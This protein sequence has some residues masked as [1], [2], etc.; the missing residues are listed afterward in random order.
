MDSEFNSRA[1]EHLFQSLPDLGQEAPPLGPQPLSWEHDTATSICLVA[2]L[3]LTAAANLIFF[4]PRAVSAREGLNG[5]AGTALNGATAASGLMKG[6]VDTLALTGLRGFAALHVAVG[7]YAS[8]SPLHV[9]LIGGASMSFF[10]LLSGFV[11]TLGYAKDLLADDSS[12]FRDFN[13][14][15]FWRNR[16]ARLFPMYM[17]TNVA[18]FLVMHYL[19]DNAMEGMS[20]GKFDMNLVFTILGLNMWIYPLDAWL[21]QTQQIELPSN[22]VTWTVQ[23]MAVFYLIF[24][25]M[26]P[27]LKAVRR[28]KLTVHLLFWLQATTFMAIVCLGLFGIDNFNWAYWTARAWPLSRVPVFAMGCLA[29]VERLHGGGNFTPFCCRGDAQAGDYGRRATILG[30]SYIL[31]L[32]LAVGINQVPLTDRYWM[33]VREAM[34]RSSWEAFVPLLFID[35]ILALTHCGDS[36]ILARACRSKPMEWMGEI[37]MSFYMIHFGLLMTVLMGTKIGYAEVPWWLLFSCFAGA[38]LAGWLLTR[39]VED[40]S[41]KCLRG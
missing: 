24:P 4:M 26:L 37:A 19:G 10:Y 30:F 36:G 33:S 22:L 35:L 7:H 41:R 34:V 31:L 17:L 5:T 29:A 9:D 13:K 21:P 1:Y 39:F 6:R 40:P 25:S 38:L 28:R 15:R 3:S 11:M 2:I 27:W 20:S 8:A 16:F 18:I 23:T 32:A 12:N 14:K